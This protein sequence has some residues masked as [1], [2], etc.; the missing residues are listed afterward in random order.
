MARASVE[1]HRSSVCA[2]E[3]TNKTLLDETRQ[4]CMQPARQ[5]SGGAVVNAV[6]TRAGARFAHLAWLGCAV[7]RCTGCSCTLS[8]FFG[9]PVSID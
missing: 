2:S 8:G 6:L 3:S 1:R 5:S 9:G 7:L 4:G